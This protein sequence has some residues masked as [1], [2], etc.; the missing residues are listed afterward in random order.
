MSHK[1]RY[2]QMRDCTGLWK[3]NPWRWI[4]TV[5]TSLQAEGHEKLTNGLCFVILRQLTAPPS[6][7]LKLIRTGNDV[8]FHR[9][10]Q[11]LLN[12]IA[13]I[14]LNLF[15][16]DR[17]W[18]NHSYSHSITSILSCA[19]YVWDFIHCNRRLNFLIL[20]YHLKMNSDYICDFHY[21]ERK[22]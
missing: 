21:V 7:L 11:K 13:N 8:N 3:V 2:T 1:Y 10:S 20:S 15:F 19:K 9:V 6:A 5:F 22:L 18:I 14:K 4:N 12:P 16:S 17:A